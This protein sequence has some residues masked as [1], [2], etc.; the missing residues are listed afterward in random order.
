MT[1][2]RNRRR[3]KI[4][5]PND[6]TLSTCL[7]VGLCI[8][9]NLS[10]LLACLPSAISAPL[11]F[12]SEGSSFYALHLEAY[13]PPPAACILQMRPCNIRLCDFG[14]QKN[15]TGIGGALARQYGNV[16]SVP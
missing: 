14:T 11:R 9:S 6:P 7:P 1:T 8:G 16:F 10:S 5:N 4:R 13:Q 15:L 3:K 12:P 2:S